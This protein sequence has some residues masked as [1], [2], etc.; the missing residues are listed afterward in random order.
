MNNLFM[1]AVCCMNIL[2]LHFAFSFF[3]LPPPSFTL[4]LK[5]LPSS[6]P[7]AFLTKLSPQT[8]NIVHGCFSLCLINEHFQWISLISWDKFPCSQISWIPILFLLYCGSSFSIT[9]PH[10]YVSILYQTSNVHHYSSIPTFT[11]NSSPPSP[12]QSL[13]FIHPLYPPLLHYIFVAVMHQIYPPPMHLSSPTLPMPCPLCPVLAFFTPPYP[14]SPLCQLSPVSHPLSFPCPTPSCLMSSMMRSSLTS[15]P[16]PSDA[17][18]PHPRNLPL[19]HPMGCGLGRGTMRWVSMRRSTRDHTTRRDYES[20]L[21]F[22]HRDRVAGTILTMVGFT[23]R[24]MGA[25]PRGGGWTGGHIPPPQVWK[26]GK[27]A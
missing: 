4:L 22:Q 18:L 1:P 15:H 5:S 2:F 7:P 10:Y 19:P 26:F 24:S 25:N 13:P 23:I 14:C 11:Y 16:R 9:L 21:V 6:L 3:V 12:T 8:W 17:P 27:Y 20:C